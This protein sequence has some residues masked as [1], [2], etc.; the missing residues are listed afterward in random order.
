MLL[1]DGWRV[2]LLRAIGTELDVRQD[3]SARRAWH[4]LLINLQEG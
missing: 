1:G 4:D 3:Q 2:D